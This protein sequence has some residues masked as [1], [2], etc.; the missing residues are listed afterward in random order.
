M[1][2]YLVEAVEALGYWMITVTHRRWDNAQ[3]W[4]D[5]V[6]YRG[7]HVPIDEKDPQV[8]TVLLLHQV[9]ADLSQAIRDD[10]DMLAERPAHH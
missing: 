7:R 8:R 1:D 10:T 5:E 9:H 3:E 2:Q 4:W 6:I